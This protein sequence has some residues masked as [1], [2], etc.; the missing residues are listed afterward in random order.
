MILLAD[1]RD[2]DEIEPTDVVDGK[3]R[4]L[5]RGRGER[6]RIE[7]EAEG[8]VIFSPTVGEL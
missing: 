2:E 6:I 7:R 8:V 5:L 4:P 1:G 3:G